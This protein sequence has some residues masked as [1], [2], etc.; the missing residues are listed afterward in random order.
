MRHNKL[1]AVQVNRFIKL[2]EVCHDPKVI[3]ALMKA[4]P[5]AV[6]KTI[7]NIAINCYKGDFMLT[8]KQKKTLK[9]YRNPISKL[10]SRTIP[11]KYKRKILAQEGGAIWIPLLVGS[12]IT[13]LGHKIFEVLQSKLS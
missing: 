6:I 9:K 5:D 4:A 1:L 10:T 7:C 11:V 8:D 12:V 3:H 13:T 2:M